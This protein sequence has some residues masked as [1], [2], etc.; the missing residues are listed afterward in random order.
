MIQRIIFAGFGGQGVLFSAKTVAYA[1]MDKGLQISWLPSYGP[2][3]RGGTANCSVIIS[4]EPIGSPII[5]KPDVLVALNR[6]S[7][8]KFVDAVLPGGV[9]IYDSS[10]IEVEIKRD[11]VTVVPIPAK[12][13]AD[14]MGSGSLGNM[15]MLGA[16]AKHTDALSL[17]DIA[18]SIKAH[19]PPKKMALAEKNIEMITKGYEFEA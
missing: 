16:Y 7:L 15:V 17:E 14:D 5:S 3:M 11:D 13:I 9:I 12:Q 10:L 18:E 4:D 1:G 2:E 19:I 6:P 8:E